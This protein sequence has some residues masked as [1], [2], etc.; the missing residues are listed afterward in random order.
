MSHPQRAVLSAVEENDEWQPHSPEE[1]QEVGTVGRIAIGLLGASTL[2]HLLCTWSDWNTYG[3]VHTYLTGGPNVDDADLNRADSIARITSIPNVIISVAAAVVFVIWLWRARVNSEVFCQADHRRSHGWV[4]ASWFCPGPNLWYPKQIVDDVWLASDQK[5]PVYADDLRRLRKP[6]LTNVWW[7]AWVGALVFDVVIRR[8]LMWMEATVG[9]LRGIALAGTASLVLTAISAVAAT[10]VIRKITT[11]Q[12]TREWIPWWDQREPRISAVPS[13]NVTRV[14]ADDDTSEQPAISE[15]IAAPARRQPQLQLAGS[16]SFGGSSFG[17]SSLGGPANPPADE[18]PKWSPFAPVV[19]SWQDSG[20]ATQQFSPAESWREDTG[21]VEEATPSYRQ[22]AAGPETP[23]WATPANPYTPANDDLLSAPQPSWQ[24]ETVAPPSL[25]V[26]QPDPYAYQP[27]ARASEPY[28]PAA[29]PEP[30][31]PS[32]ARSYTEPYSS[33]YSSSSDYL[34]SSEPVA[35]PAAAPAPQRAPEPEPAPVAR[36]GR[37][38]ARVAVDS[39]STIQ[40]A[41]PRSASYYGQAPAISE[42][43]D[44]LTPSKPLP[45]VPSFGPEPSYSP[46]PEPTYA[47]EPTYPA[48]DAPAVPSTYESSY[49]PDYS[50]SYQYSEPQ[51]QPETT[52]MPGTSYDSS[53]YQSYSSEPS[54]YDNYNSTYDSSYSSQQSSYGESEYRGESYDTSYSPN[55]TQESSS[56]DHSTPEYGSYSDSGQQATDYQQTPYSYET[57]ARPAA[58]EQVKDDSEITAPRTHPRRRWV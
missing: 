55:Y 46:G 56:S 58:P 18:A 17:G 11:M 32:W 39:P 51:Q 3:V 44:F 28:Q 33:S 50:S 36:A 1:F 24:A 54:S 52:Y 20:P 29:R 25:S 38:A 2:T 43:D 49:T 12:T 23:S 10:L 57:P 34:T 14:L 16:P 45:P 48:Y 15:P 8:A 40:A 53:S 42:L 21:Q 37:R 22:S 5:T 31:E 27:A 47:P 35:P 4:L 19:E 6:F 41:V 26:A 9:S 30:S 7:V 13:Y